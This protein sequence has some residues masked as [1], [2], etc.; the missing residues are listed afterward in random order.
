VRKG[1]S[2][3]NRLVKNVGTDEEALMSDARGVWSDVFS[4]ESL[5]RSSVG[6]WGLEDVAEGVG[7]VEDTK[8]KGP[9]NDS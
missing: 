3:A 7:S 2:E 8:L 9:R 5:G 6:I 4:E 1:D